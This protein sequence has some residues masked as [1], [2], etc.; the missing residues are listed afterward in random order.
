MQN[1][2]YFLGDKETREVVV[3]DPA[4]RPDEILKAAQEE[5][6][7]IVGALVTHTH[8][9]HVNAAQDLLK[10]LDIPIYIHDAEKND[11]PIR[12][13]SIKPTRGG[14]RIQVGNIEIEFIHTPGHTPGSQCFRVREALVSGDTLFIN[15]C[16]RTD[17][18]GGSPDEMY[19][20]LNQTLKKLPDSTILFPGHNYADKPESTLGDEKRNNPYLLCEN[21]EQFLSFKGF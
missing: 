6:L 8:F 18:P 17:L 7:K 14:D 21:L 15:S 11:V 16:G 19:K 12:L 3:V 2:V 10:K 4:W 9:D 13:S 5:G 1:F 20:S